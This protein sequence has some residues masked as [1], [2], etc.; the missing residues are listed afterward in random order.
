MAEPRTCMCILYII[1]SC[2]MQDGIPGEVS[3]AEVASRRYKF[4]RDINPI[5]QPSSAAAGPCPRHDRVSTV[6][7]A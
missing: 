7:G 1:M 2:V 5:A 3:V 4:S 6:V